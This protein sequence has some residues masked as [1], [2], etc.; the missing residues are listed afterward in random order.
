MCT[1]F[2]VLVSQL[3]GAGGIACLFV[4]FFF[5]V[6]SR[7]AYRV[8]SSHLWHQSIC[9]PCIFTLATKDLGVHTKRGSSLI[10]MGV[11]GGAWYPPAQGSIADRNTRLSYIVPFT[12]YAGMSAFCQVFF[13][14]ALIIDV[15]TYRIP[16]HSSTLCRVSP[17]M[18]E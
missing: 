17:I 8:S 16:I 14:G 13:R 7:R 10:V 9:Y 3:P 1:T 11:G 2:S 12:G 6:R 5:E 18:L 15:L 4:V